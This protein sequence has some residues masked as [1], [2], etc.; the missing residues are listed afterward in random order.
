MRV[1]LFKI[2]R[3]SE[4][5]KKNYIKYRARAFVFIFEELIYVF[6]ISKNDLKIL[7]F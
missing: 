4:L 2:L 5:N 7:L 6:Y 1:L 3:D